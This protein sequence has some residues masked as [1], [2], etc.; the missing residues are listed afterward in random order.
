[1][2]GKKSENSWS[3]QG[4]R[5]NE[6][7]NLEKYR[8]EKEKEI[9]KMRQKIE[10]QKNTIDDLQV[11][12]TK[13]NEDFARQQMEWED[14]FSAQQKIIDRF[15]QET[16][17]YPHAGIDDIVKKN[18]RLSLRLGINGVKFFLCVQ[19]QMHILINETQM[20][21]VQFELRS[22]LAKMAKVENDLTRL[23]DTV[24]DGS[25]LHS[26]LEQIHRNLA[27]HKR[28]VTSIEQTLA[29][30]I[31]MQH[32]DLGVYGRDNDHD[33]EH[34]D[35]DDHDHDH[36]NDNKQ[37][38]TK[39]KEKHAMNK[40][41]DA[42][43]NK[44]NDDGNDDNNDDDDDDDDDGGEFKTG[45]KGA[46]KKEKDNNGNDDIVVLR[47]PSHHMAVNSFE[48]SAILAGLNL[49]KNKDN[50]NSSKKEENG[51]LI[52][53]LYMVG[54]ESTKKKQK[55]SPPGPSSP[56]NSGTR[57][58][59]HKS[60][61]LVNG[62]YLTTN[63]LPIQEAMSQ[64]PREPGTPSITN[65]YNGIDVLDIDETY[66]IVEEDETL[67][68][69][70]ELVPLQAEYYE[71]TTTDADA[72]QEN[73]HSHRVNNPS[74]GQKETTEEEEEEE[75]EENGNHSH[76]K[77]SSSNSKTHKAEE[78]SATNGSAS[79]VNG[80]RRESSR[81]HKRT[82]STFSDHRSQ[83]ILQLQQDCIQMRLQIVRLEKEKEQWVENAQELSKSVKRCDHLTEL[84]SKMT[85]EKLQLRLKVE[86]LESM[87]SKHNISTPF[88]S[89][90]SYHT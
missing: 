38:N 20:Q 56:P 75:E 84:L 35:N 46:N 87:L 16:S 76:P 4:R 15:T 50:E 71:S 57:H 28:S 36:D 49:D 69:P 77:N 52:S 31:D 43:K 19:K 72:S 24:G 78:N 3:S 5:K 65:E 79:Q 17:Q 48:T 39:S 53:V 61:S 45:K 21:N 18:R 37:S 2:G 14:K 42:S 13:Q 64:T 82:S 51:R 73:A 41:K 85:E 74:N 32:V 68:S 59:H 60:R 86:E 54:T 55:N 90:S 12:I 44:Q 89:K 30:N 40:S 47:A 7:D 27:R 88:H 34:E 29:E 23:L 33:D 63:M 6:D 26:R 9:M 25:Q 10:D 11:S 67:A 1:G 70:M 83:Q 80:K 62:R 8:E 66:D 58:K 22:T 81:S